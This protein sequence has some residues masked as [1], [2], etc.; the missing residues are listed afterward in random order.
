VARLTLHIN[1]AA[2]S[3]PKQRKNERGKWNLPAPINS[4]PS[5]SLAPSA[6]KETYTRRR[7]RTRPHKQLESVRDWE[8][9]IGDWGERRGERGW[10]RGWGDEAPALYSN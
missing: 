10:G 8:L 3:S 7:T 6:H 5:N 2:P 9:G 1:S 4:V